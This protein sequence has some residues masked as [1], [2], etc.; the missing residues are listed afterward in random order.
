MESIQ[1]QSMEVETQWPLLLL[2]WAQSVRLEYSLDR[3]ARIGQYLCRSSYVKN[4]NLD[5]WWQSEEIICQKSKCDKWLLDWERNSRE[6][7]ERTKTRRFDIGA[8]SLFSTA[9]ENRFVTQSIWQHSWTWYSHPSAG[10][11]SNRM[12]PSHSLQLS[13]YLST[14]RFEWM[15][16]AT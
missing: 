7:S 2:G 15:Q 10:R 3:C 12:P 8:P 6:C 4:I 11:N 16:T 9:Q 1:K 5:S 13:R 14:T